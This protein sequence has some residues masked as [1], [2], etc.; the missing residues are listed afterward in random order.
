MS[1]P[2]T[3]KVGSASVTA[4]GESSLPRLTIRR[5]AH[6]CSRPIVAAERI[7]FPYG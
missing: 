3:P 6:K 2:K 5:R 7:A 1:P 4:Q